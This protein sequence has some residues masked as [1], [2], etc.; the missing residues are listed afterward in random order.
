[1][2]KNVIVAFSIAICIFAI[3]AI[4]GLVNQDYLKLIDK[5]KPG[6][7]ETTT[8]KTSQ[9][10]TKKDGNKS[11]KYTFYLNENIIEKLNVSY[12][13]SND[14]TEYE[15]LKSYLT[16]SFGGI[17]NK[18][19]LG[20]VDKYVFTFDINDFNDS[21]NEVDIIKQLNINV[22]NTNVISD[23]IVKLDES[24]FTC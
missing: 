15:L 9:E 14:E 4:Y 16:Q 5:G 3:F 22:Y 18:H 8:I 11:Y 21:L 13:N 6:K 24:G 2:N 19:L 23:Y 10:C 12:E 17:T 20:K 7:T 1:M